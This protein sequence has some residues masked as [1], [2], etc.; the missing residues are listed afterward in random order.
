[1]N[2]FHPVGSFLKDKEVAEALA[3]Q[4]GAIGVRAKLVPMEFADFSTKLN[5]RE[6]KGLAYNRRGVNT[7][8]LS[9][10]YRWSLWSKGVY[11]YISDPQ[12]DAWFLESE[13]MMDMEKRYQMFRD[14]IEPYIWDKMVPE[15]ALFD[16]ANVFGLTKRLDCSQVNP[17]EPI[18]LRGMRSVS[19]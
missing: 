8:D 5:Q 3:G 11:P 17:K 12:F 4:L 6:L 13:S 19:E 10:G 14:T 18:D 7:G 1:M 15:V 9:D 2:L 16:L